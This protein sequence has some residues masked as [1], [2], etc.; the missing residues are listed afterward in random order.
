MGRTS[1]FAGADDNRTSS[2]A[3]VTSRSPLLISVE[4]IEGAAEETV[5]EGA[6]ETVEGV[7]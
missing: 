3:R 1:P 5:E 6:G 4:A 2:K 7:M